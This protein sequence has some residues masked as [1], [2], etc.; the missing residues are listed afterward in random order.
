MKAKDIF[1]LTEVD[2]SLFFPIHYLSFEEF[3]QMNSLELSTYQHYDC[4]MILADQCD[5][6]IFLY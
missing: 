1:K 6:L 4:S 2:D 5:K 3:D